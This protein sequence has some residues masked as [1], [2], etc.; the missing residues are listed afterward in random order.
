M[1]DISETERSAESGK[2]RSLEDDPGIRE[3]IREA[4]RAIRVGHGTKSR[5]LSAEELELAIDDL[6][7]GRPSRFLEHQEP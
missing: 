6:R 2:L 5:H 4:E 3:R 1:T 7:A